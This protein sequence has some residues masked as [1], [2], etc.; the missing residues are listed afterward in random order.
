MDRLG[1]SAF[2]V[3]QKAPT[4]PPVPTFDEV[5]AHMVE[6]AVD[7]LTERARKQWLRELR[8]RVYIDVRL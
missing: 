5:R 3:V 7:D 6:R 4:E 1:G 2:L 8:R